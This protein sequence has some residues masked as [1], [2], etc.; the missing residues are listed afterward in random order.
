VFETRQTP[1]L[2]TRILRE[3]LARVKA[4]LLVSALRGLDAR[5]ALPILRHLSERSRSASLCHNASDVK[6][7]NAHL[8]TVDR[9]K[10]VD[11]LLN[12]AHPDNGGKAQFF[13]SCG[14]SPEHPEL[15]AEALRHVAKEGEVVRRMESAH[16][17]KS[18]VDGWLSVHTEDGRRRSVRTIWIIDAGKDAPRL[19]TAYPGQE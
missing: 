5:Q 18:I 8:S 4:A 17:E 10:I 1:T 12:E 15:L 2:R 19:V 3:R 9:S 13:M 16:G 11:Y 6:L 14:F 7:R